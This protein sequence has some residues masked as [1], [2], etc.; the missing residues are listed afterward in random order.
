MRVL[1]KDEIGFISGG[2]AADDCMAKYLQDNSLVGLMNA[3]GVA[4]ICSLVGAL[5]IVMNIMAIAFAGS[6]VGSGIGLYAGTGMLG[7][8]GLGVAGGVVGGF[9]GIIAGESMYAPH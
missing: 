2:N 3:F 9:A 5:E 7:K 6:L 4:P 8:V 1:T